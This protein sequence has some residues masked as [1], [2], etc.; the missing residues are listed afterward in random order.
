MT[1]IVTMNVQGL[2]NAEK[3]KQVFLFCKKMKYDI[4]FMQEVHSTEEYEKIFKSEWGGQILFSHG[5]SNSRGCAIL[6]NPSLNVEVVKTTSDINGRYILCDTKIMQ[7]EVTLV[8]LYA[9]NNDDPAYFVNVFEKLSEH[10]FADKIIGGD[11][12]LVLDTKLDSLNR[13]NNNKKACNVLKTFMDECLIADPWRERNGNLFQ[14]TWYKKRPKEMFARLDYMLVNYA[15]VSEIKQISNVPS[16]RSD[17]NAVKMEIN[18]C[19]GSPRGPGFW[20]LNESLL[21]DLNSVQ[22]INQSVD[23]LVERSRDWEPCVRWEKLKEVMVQTCQRIS[24]KKAEASKKTMHTLYEAL[25]KA[26]QRYRDADTKLE[27]EAAEEDKE[28]YHSE[29]K[30][31]LTYKADG[32]RIRSRTLWY[33]NS[34]RNSR[35]FFALEKVKYSNKTLSTVQCEDGTITRDERKILNE[36]KKFYKRLYSK[37][38]TVAFCFVNNFDIQHTAESQSKME[39][40][41]T[42]EEF[43]KALASMARGKAP[44]NDGLTCAFYVVMWNKIGRILFNAVLQS[45]MNKKMYKSA[46]RGVISLIP[47]RGKNALLLS[48]WRPICLLN[49]DLKIVTKMVTNRIKPYLY[50]VIGTQQTG[51]VPKRFIGVNLRKI[52]DLI[53]YLEQNECSMALINVDF[54]KCF[55]SISHEALMQSLKFFKVPEYIISWVVMLYNDFE[56]CVINNGKWSDY[57]PQHRG[58]HQ[59]SALSGPV[60]LYVAEILALRINANNK[61]QGIQIDGQNEKLSQYADDTSIWSIFQEESINQVISELEI[62]KRNTGL[63]ANYEK[64]IIYKIGCKTGFKKRLYLDKKVKWGDNVIDALGLLIST[65]AE[66]DNLDLNYENVLQKASTVLNVWQHR[67][68][69]IIGKI[70]VVNTLINSL[71]TYKMQLLPIMSKEIEGKITSMISRFIWN[72]RKPKI[73]MMVLYM[74]PQNGGRNLGNL[75]LRDKSLKLEWIRRLHSEQCSSFFR[76][77][78][79]NQLNCGFKNELIWECNFNATD[80]VKFECKSAFWTDVLK[81]WAEYNFVNPQCP[82]EVGNQIL[83]YNSL[84]RVAES[85]VF[86]KEWYEKG[87][88]YVKDLVRND[89][90]VSL[91][92]LCYLYDESFSAMKYNCLISA[93]PRVWKRMITNSDND[94]DVEWQSKYSIL[95][96]RKKWSQSMY[97]LWIENWSCTEEASVKMSRLLNVHVNSDDAENGFRVV[98]KITEISKYKAFQYRLLHNAIFLN[99]RLIHLQISQTNLCSQCNLEKETVSHLFWYCL[100]TKRLIKECFDYIRIQGIKDNDYTINLK[101]VFLSTISENPYSHVNTLITIIKQKIYAHKCIKQKLRTTNVISE[102]EFIHQ[103]ER[104]RAIETGNHKN[105]NRRWPDKLPTDNMEMFINE[106]LN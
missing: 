46:R 6:F 94:S 95:S 52:I 51:Y 16:F 96:E 101:N 25:K 30:K 19:K 47:K 82:E 93:T 75:L 15:L 66:N 49:N 18:L 48:S 5:E 21:Y 53:Q 91:E 63:K 36:Q 74:K 57:F 68:L 38:P 55:D 70:E 27:K 60:F 78:V 59:G 37:D 45:H 83:W 67:G 9:P 105:Y 31:Y 98:N 1:I 39:E 24:K 65:D 99:D 13:L 72:G 104:K 92:Q 85:F 3:R 84:I 2:Q 89:K 62:F 26:D 97:R 43:T 106:Y 81:T 80:V 44:G 20:K 33:Q 28:M 29:L 100:E 23:D 42:F 77:L 11:L 79:Y 22:E 32:A 71:F 56:L 90:I 4:I 35:Y 87:I 69:S 10:K 34:E 50:E 102:Y 41:F 58:V 12:N 88:I 40:E 8:C 7:K 64:T 76:A 86:Y 103:M 73:R 14:F 54:E 61:I 17:H